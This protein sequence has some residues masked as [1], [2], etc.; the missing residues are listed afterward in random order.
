MPYSGC[1][2]C[3]SGGTDDKSLIF[4]YA[5]GH[6]YQL[7][8][9][10]MTVVCCVL[11]NQRHMTSKFYLSSIENCPPAVKNSTDILTEGGDT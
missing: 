6:S 3:T 8:C 7:T 9:E 10:S 11:W 4:I 5:I 2:F 1:R